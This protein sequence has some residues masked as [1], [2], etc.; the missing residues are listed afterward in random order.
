MFIT[1]LIFFLPYLVP[2][3]LILVAVILVHKYSRT[4]DVGLLWLAIAVVVWPLVSRLIEHRAFAH[5]GSDVQ[6]HPVGFY[7]FL[8]AKGQVSPGTL[9]LAFTLA[10]QFIGAGFLL[11]AALYLYRG[12]RNATQ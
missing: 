6:G 5:F 9:L 1:S 7:Q 12:R 8:V 4:R 11:L 2:V 3:L 10:Q